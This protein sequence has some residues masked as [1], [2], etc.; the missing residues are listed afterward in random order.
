[1]RHDRHPLDKN[2]TVPGI[3]PG[4]W[5]SGALARNQDQTPA[6]RA[7]REKDAR[8]RWNQRNGITETLTERENA[9]RYDR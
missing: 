8:K 3:G 4:G 7:H 1:M 9:R 2:R 5:D 6:M